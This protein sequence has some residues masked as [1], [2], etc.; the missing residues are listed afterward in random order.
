[1]L[2]LLLMLV[3]SFDTH[4][5]INGMRA[6]E[7]YNNAVLFELK[8]PQRKLPVC[9]ATI[10][11]KR[12]ILTA[13][14][15][16]VNKHLDIT[17]VDVRTLRVQLN[18]ISHQVSAHS[19][20]LEYRIKKKEQD[21]WRDQ[22]KGNWGWDEQRIF[23]SLLMETATADI[24]LI[25]TLNDIDGSLPRTKL[26]YGSV[27]T[28]SEVVL[29]GF[30]D[31]HWG[32]SAKPPYELHYGLNFLTADHPI[33]YVLKVKAS[34]KLAISA[35]GDSGGPLMKVSGHQVGVLSAGGE[36]DGAL[37]S[38]YVPLRPWKKYLEARIR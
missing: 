4:A 20:P 9:T 19:I 38:F 32:I 15:C 14:H 2:I 36:F 16:V 28:H 17:L 37:E 33:I 6:E 24:A 21:M 1:M 13:A 11:G 7:N 26:N 5:I 23:R 18:G 22:S 25:H 30:G 35:K 8:G 12:T 27:P 3:L 31:T 10:V 34:E 29:A